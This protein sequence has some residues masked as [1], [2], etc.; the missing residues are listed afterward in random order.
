MRKKSWKWNYAAVLVAE[1][2]AILGFALSMPVIPLF[3][4]DE[5]GVSDQQQL[6]LWTGLIQS[7]A[8][9]ALAVFAPVWGRLADM[10]SRRAMLMRA[11]FGGAIV[12]SA[13]AFVQAPW[14]LMVLRTLQGCLT[15]TIA[16][17]SVLTVGITPRASLTMAL[18]LLQT[19]I[20]VGNSLGPLAGGLIVDFWGHR[21]AFLG[22]GLVLLAAALIVLRG[23]T[24]DPHHA[25]SAESARGKGK[26][27]RKG[28][29]W[30]IKLASN[31][32]VVLL[33]SVSF[34]FQM[35]N[36]TAN[37]IMPLFLRE[38]SGDSRY[39]G[40]YAGL[41]LGIGAAAGAIGTIVSGKFCPRL[42]YWKMVT[43]CLAGG[44]VGVIPQAFAGSLFQLATIHVIPSMFLGGISP[45]LQAL[46]AA[47]TDHD[48]QGR[49]FGINTSVSSTG[50]ALG[51]L[52]GSAAAMLSYRAV[53]PVTGL[54]LSLPLIRLLLRRTRAES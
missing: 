22:T 26:L 3:L 13:M 50:A 49:V 48:H 1:T 10:Y 37:P 38:I 4:V 44:C 7:C 34:L 27:K 52:I 43:L 23:V 36:T 14:Q 41:V 16:A 35:A 54:L 30:D 11:M 20:Y 18:G 29:F 45:A 53:F 32:D 39:I 19:G 2:L 17:A 47:H 40:S 6:K 28:F 51:P 31:S 33:L 21:A 15:G 46:L 12:V 25:S 42:G 5:I 24:E 9:I 8:S